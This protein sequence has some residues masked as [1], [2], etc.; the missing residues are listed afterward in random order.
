MLFPLIYRQFAGNLL[1]VYVVFLPSRTFYEVA[2]TYQVHGI[3][4]TYT[5]TI[6]TYHIPLELSTGPE[7]DFGS[8][9]QFTQ[10]LSFQFGVFGTGKTP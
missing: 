2:T 5:I 7:R 4:T 1:M 3:Y 9:S 10:N 8:Q 6:T